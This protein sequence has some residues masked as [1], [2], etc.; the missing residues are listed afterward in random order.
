VKIAHVI[1]R[2][3]AGGAQRNTHLC[4]AQQQR[5]GH[6]VVLISG[7]ETSSEGCLFQEV[8]VAPYRWMPLPTLVREVSPRRDA[9]AFFRLLSIFRSEKFDLVHTHTSKAGILGRLAAWTAGVPIVVHTPHG[10]VFHSYFSKTKTKIFEYIER[11][12]AFTVDSLILLSPGELQDHIQVK[13]APSDRSVIIPSGVNLAPFEHL[14]CRS[15]SFTVGYVGRLADI[16]G[17]V[18]LIDAFAIHLQKYPGSRLLMVVGWKQDVAPF[19][20]HMSLLA[21]PSHNEG[22]GRVVVEAMSAGLA[23]LATSV[24][25]LLDLVVP[26]YNG[27]L[28]EPQRPDLLAAALDEL[29]EKQLLL[30]GMGENG[31]RRAHNFSEEVMFGRLELLYRRLARQRSVPY[32][33]GSIG[34]PADLPG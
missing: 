9:L 5:S 25:G 29:A 24:G 14:H 31:R 15:D 28:V 6:E 19:L 7:T 1:T 30:Q 8:E 18:D 23:V 13:V 3:V 4:A 34:Q 27:L 33:N 20:R 32:G 2:L 10:H 16:K 22:M 21:V 17:P 12:I 26:G 11:A